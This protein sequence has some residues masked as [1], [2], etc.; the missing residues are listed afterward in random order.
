LVVLG[1]DATTVLGLTNTVLTQAG[2]AG[3]PAAVAIPVSAA[4]TTDLAAVLK[5]AIDARNLPGIM[6]TQFGSR[7][8]VEGANSVSGVGARPLSAIQDLAGNP[9]KANQLDGSTTLTIFLGEGLDYGDAH[10]SSS[11]GVYQTTSTDGGPS[12]RVIDGLSLGPTVTVDAD[13][14]LDDADLDDGVVFTSGF[15]AGFTANS[16]VLV[17]NTTGRTAYVSLWIDFNGDGVFAPTERFLNAQAVVNPTTAFSVLV[18]S[19]AMLGDTFMRVRLSTDPAAIASPITPVGSG[20]ARD[21]EVEDHRITIR[22]NPFTNPNVATDPNAAFD[23]NNDGFVSPIDILQIINWY[24]DPNKPRSLTLAAATGLPPFVDVNGDA[25]VSPLDILRIINFLNARA[26]GGGEGEAEGE[27]GGIDAGLMSAFGSM[28]T[29]VLASDWAAGLETVL[30]SNKQSV[31]QAGAT[32]HPHDVAI[33]TSSEERLEYSFAGA[34]SANHASGTDT[35][36][37]ELA[38]ESE[39]DESA[40]EGDTLVDPLLGYWK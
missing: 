24:N 8:V 33:L 38:G 26:A 34:S 32:L 15:F 16:Q 17:T 19:T 18:P 35:F 39:D 20:P 1:G 2:V 14:R 10:R 22:G 21:G 11:G 29:T 7:L 36:W 12:H 6:V 28:E 25:L 40:D 5:S 30:V 13:A 37:A 9:L 27:F 31:G 4:G 3:Q 23:V